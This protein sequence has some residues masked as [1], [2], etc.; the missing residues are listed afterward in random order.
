MRRLPRWSLAVLVAVTVLGG[1]LRFDAAGDPGQYHSR[2]AIA[3][4]MI[5]RGIVDKGTYGLLGGGGHGRRTRCTGR[6][7]RRPCSRSRTR[8]TRAP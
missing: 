6:R 3:Y 5:A 2:D 4:S 7:A 8:S 1:A